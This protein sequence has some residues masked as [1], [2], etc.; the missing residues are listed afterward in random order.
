MKSKETQFKAEIDLL[1]SNYNQLLNKIIEL[2]MII[3]KKN[4]KI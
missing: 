4:N 3:E 1:Q 2:E